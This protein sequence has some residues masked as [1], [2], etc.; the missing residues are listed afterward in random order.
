MALGFQPQNSLFIEQHMQHMQTNILAGGLGGSDKA[1]LAWPNVL[2]CW[3]GETIFHISDTTVSFKV[4]HLLNL[5]CVP[6]NN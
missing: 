2:H 1:W 5:R 3:G 4:S 6:T